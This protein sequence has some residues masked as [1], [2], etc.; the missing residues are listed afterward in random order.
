[1]RA[2]ATAWER[3]DMNGYFGAYVPGF[4]GNDGSASEWQAGRRLRILGK[5]RISLELSGITVELMPG[6]VARAS[7]RQDYS[8][9]QLRASGQ[10]VLELVRRD[11]RWLIRKESVS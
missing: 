4:R 10:K 5:N 8:A 6:N 1:M 9:D 7:F 11:G 2:W 3:K